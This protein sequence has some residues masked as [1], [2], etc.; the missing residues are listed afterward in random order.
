MFDISTAKGL[1]SH[2]EHEEF[3]RVLRSFVAKF[4]LFA[5]KSY[6]TG[7]A[8]KTIAEPAGR[9]HPN[10]W[11]PIAAEVHRLLGRRSSVIPIPQPPSRTRQH[12]CC[13]WR[14]LVRRCNTRT[15]HPGKGCHPT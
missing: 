4:S 15:S 5:V 14:R 2:E 6:I 10:M 8:S 12:L 7:E 11:G 3:L 1:V 13:H 9:N